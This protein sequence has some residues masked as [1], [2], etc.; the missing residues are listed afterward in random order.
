MTPHGTDPP[1]VVVMGVSGTGKSTVGRLLAVRL[2]VPFADADELHPPANI[3]KMA[4]G[5]PLDDADRLPWLESVGRLLR[6]HQEDGTGAV[7]TCSALRRRYRDVLRAACPGAFFL[8]LTGD[9]RL[10]AERIGRRSGHFMPAGL[11]DSQLRTL[12]P[13]EPGEDGTS[14]DVTPPP[15][16]VAA[17]AARLFRGTADGTP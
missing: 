12:E 6:T 11:L 4:S 7:V 14:I 16:E 2:G 1:S 8:H 13:L 10:L 17:T 15:E 9:P 5:V 3:A